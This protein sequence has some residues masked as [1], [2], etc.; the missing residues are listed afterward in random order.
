MVILPPESSTWPNLKV[1]LCYGGFPL[2]I[3]GA[4]SGCKK[5][6]YS[7]CQLVLIELPSWKISYFRLRESEIRTAGWWMFFGLIVNVAAFILTCNS[8]FT[9]VFVEQMTMSWCFYLVILCIFWI[10][11]P[12]DNL[13]TTSFYKVNNEIILKAKTCFFL[14]L[15]GIDSRPLVL[16][17]GEGLTLNA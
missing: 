14:L 15:C 16:R 6:P 9:L 10:V 12:N 1:S 11:V 5:T 7:R 8:Y 3:H 2:I 17:S 4:G 13:V